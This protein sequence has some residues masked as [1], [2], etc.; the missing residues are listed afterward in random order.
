MIWASWVPLGSALG[1]LLG[2]VGQL[3]TFLHSL[4]GILEPS[5]L[6][7]AS[8]WPLRAASGE[9]NGRVSAG[10]PRWLRGRPTQTRGGLFIYMAY[11]CVYIYMYI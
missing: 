9:R 2:R 11:V 7:L 4:G 8:S 1:V 10:V 3:G 5:W 6:D